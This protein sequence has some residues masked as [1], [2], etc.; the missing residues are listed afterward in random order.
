MLIK[1]IPLLLQYI[2][3]GAIGLSILCFGLDR[4]ISTKTYVVTSCI[5][6]YIAICICSLLHKKLTWLANGELAD[7]LYA[8]VILLVFSVIVIILVNQKWMNNILVFLFRRS[9]HDDIWRNVIDFDNGSNVKV[10]LKDKGYYIIGHFGNI[11]ESNTD[12]K[13]I[14]ISAPSKRYIDTNELLENVVD[15][16]QDDSVSILIRES[17]IDQIVIF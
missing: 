15:N 5:M 3:P 12:S 16:S 2:V 9:V 6:S 17:E 1:D 7:S 14:E 8:T 4:K 10:Y 11:E 13:W